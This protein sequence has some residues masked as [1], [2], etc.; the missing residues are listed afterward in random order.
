[1]KVL[2][3]DTETTGLWDFKGPYYGPKQP[4]LVQLGIKLVEVFSNQTLETYDA[5]VKPVLYSDIPI[6]A[7][8]THKITIE[9]ANDLGKD[10]G[11][12]L[13][14]FNAMAAEADY[15]CAHN[16]Q[17]D[18]RIMNRFSYAMKHRI[19]W[20]SALCTMKIMTPI[21]KLPGKYGY[22]W[23]KLEELHKFLFGE[24][25]DNAHNALADVNALH[26]C[27]IEM[28]HRKYIPLKKKD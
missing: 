24:S 28:M 9:I 26:K 27:F 15:V 23:P 21:C 22:K 11:E 4:H 16:W 13:Q 25:F 6:E 19:D 10:P 20:V 8:N 18:Q 14:V 3:F 2:F 1:M 7:T 17:F 5:I 12:V